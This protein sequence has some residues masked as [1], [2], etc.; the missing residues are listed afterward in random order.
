MQANGVQP[1]AITYSTILS[2]WVKAGKLYRAAKLFEKLR[3]AGTEIDPVLYQTM[4]VGYERAGLVSQA[5]RLYL[6]HDLKEPEGIAKET[7]IRILAN[8]G[9]VDEATWL[10]RRAQSHDGLVREEP[11]APECGGGCVCVGGLPLKQPAKPRLKPAKKK[12]KLNTS[13]LSTPTGHGPHRGGPRG[14]PKRPT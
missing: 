3:E 9:R 7:A 5:K 1:N 11:E 4:V 12:P 14:P 2:I 8:A 13:H 10:F 6:L